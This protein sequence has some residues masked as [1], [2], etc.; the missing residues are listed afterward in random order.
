M[1]A[2]YGHATRHWRNQRL[3]AIALVVLG[4]W[5]L[6]SFLS[7]PDP[8]YANVRA[9]LAAP[10]QA[11]L[12]AIFGWCTLWHSAQGVQVVVDDYAGRDWHGRLRWGSRI[13]HLAAAAALAWA[14]WTLARGN[15]A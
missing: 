14:L 13:L 9:W 4:S 15:V 2:T 1:S 12:M 11:A 10:G 6:Y 5:F 8:G 7:L 3:S